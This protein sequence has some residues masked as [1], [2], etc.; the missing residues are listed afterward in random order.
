MAIAD[1]GVAC[2]DAKYYYHYPRPIQTMPGFKTILGTP[3]FP[4]YTSGH[5]AFSGAAAEVLAHFFPSQ[6]SQFRTWAEEAAMSRIYGGIHYQFDADAGL[7]QG[8]KSAAYSVARAK[9]DG[10]D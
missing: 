1:A 7:D 3:N 6:A 4:A 5:A 10:V 2:W 9:Q 8:R